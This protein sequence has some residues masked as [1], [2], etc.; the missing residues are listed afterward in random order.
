M[1]A[2]DQNDLL[3]NRI[4]QSNLESFKLSIETSLEEIKP[5]VTEKFWCR[6]LMPRKQVTEILIESF[7]LSVR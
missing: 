3:S 7:S 2:K 6:I 1:W 5:K 4:S